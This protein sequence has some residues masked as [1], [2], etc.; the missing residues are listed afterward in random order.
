[1][2]RFDWQGEYWKL[3]GAFG[4]LWRRAEDVFGTNSRLLTYIERIEKTNRRLQTDNDRVLDDN[5]RLFNEN[6]RLRKQ[7]VESAQQTEARIAEEIQTALDAAKA[8]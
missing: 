5:T 2:A 8:S 4:S 7:A 1:M 6:N 3:F